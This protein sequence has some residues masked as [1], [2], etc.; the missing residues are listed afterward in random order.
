MLRKLTTRAIAQWAVNC[1]DMRDADAIMTPFE[2]DE[3]PWD[4]WSVLGRDNNFIPLDGD[5]ATDENGDL[6]TGLS[7]VLDWATIL[8]NGLKATTTV[9]APQNARRPNLRNRVGCRAA[10]ASYYRDTRLTRSKD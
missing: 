7:A 6:T 4:G 5:L 3:N 8:T 2:Y 9:P 10:R 1:A